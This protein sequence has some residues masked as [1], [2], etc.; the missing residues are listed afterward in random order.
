MKSDHL[1]STVSRKQKQQINLYR[2]TCTNE[3]EV[4]ISQINVLHILGVMFVMHVLPR[5]GAIVQKTGS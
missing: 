3:Y 5:N 2:F 4:S 1:P